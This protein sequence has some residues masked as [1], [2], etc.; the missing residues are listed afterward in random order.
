MRIGVKLFVAFLC[1]LTLSAC[2]VP[3]GAAL[4]KEIT[5]EAT[6]ENPTVE[7]VLVSR[8]KVPVVNSWP[9]TGWH[10]HYHWLGSS[11]GHDSKVIR[12]GD[13]V[14]LIIWD[15][16][17]NSLL[18]NEAEKAVRME[19]LEVS[20]GGAIFVPYID[21]VKISGLTPDQ[22]RRRIQTRLEPV[23]PSAQVQLTMAAGFGNS[24]DLVSGVNSPGSYPMPNQNF[25][26]LSLIAQGGG[27]STQLRNPLVR[28]IRGG[29]TY[30]IRS[31]A[32][33]STAHKNTRL[34]GGDK[35]VVT[36]DD[37]YFTAIGASGTE[38][39]I[40]FP[41]EHVTALEAI[42]LMGGLIDDRADPQ[43]VLILREYDPLSIRYDE[44]GPSRQQVIFAFDLTSADGL[45]AARN[46]RVNP[47][48]TVLATESPA[49]KTRTIL[50][51]FGT[52][53]GS[54]V[55]AS[56]AVR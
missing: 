36:E 50:G 9:V 41:K 26:I 23:V 52:V 12:P 43:G 25:T 11:H 17:P 5:R 19:G 35:I 33:F 1:A 13:T 10:G 8:A 4:Q 29:S 47:G 48:D 32:L 24:V 34:F 15:S 3:R 21:T 14:N 28:L 7:V 27:I 20:G 53:L 16:Q 51:L 46:F 45:F 55:Q 56:N 6:A 44:S 18:T 30:E 37:R 2:N 49:V 42:S 40:Y 39:I 22:A 38:D 31:E 54:A